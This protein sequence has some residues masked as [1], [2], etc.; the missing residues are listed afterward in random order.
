M[1]PVT[2][3]FDG[4]EVSPRSAIVP[5]CHRI[6]ERRF[7]IVG[8]GFYLTRYGL[9]ASAGHV[10]ESMV[11][12]KSGLI[13]DAFVLQEHG[14]DSIL[15]RRLVSASVSTSSDVGLVQLETETAKG[16]VAPN[17]RVPLSWRRPEDG[18]QVVAYAYPQNYEIVFE[19]GLPSPVIKCDYIEG[20]F[21]SELSVN[22]RPNL[23]YPHYET[24]LHVPD[25][26]SGA[27][28]FDKHGHVIGICCRGWDFGEELASE[29][30]LS[31]VLPSVYLR[32]VGETT[33][34][35]P[36][37]SWEYLQLPDAV[38]GTRL[39]FDSLVEHE[40]VI[41]HTGPRRGTA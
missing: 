18:E 30:P 37:Y 25:G 26:A 28:V 35:P 29:P 19:P 8:T 14:S 40:H 7:K 27:P 21:L 23:R 36:S 31:S 9:L 11:S 20:Q 32:T 22:E 12:P 1:R 2:L 6:G 34:T 4:K 10:L 3:D 33:A 15:Y 38:R 39:T 41:A 24:S 5:I 13:E 16:K 17:P